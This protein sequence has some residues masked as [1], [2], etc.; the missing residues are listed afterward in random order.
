MG[1]KNQVYGQLQPLI[2]AFLSVPIEMPLIECVITGTIQQVSSTSEFQQ[3]VQQKV[4]KWKWAY[5]IQ[6]KEHL[7]FPLTR[8]RDLPKT[9]SLTKLYPGSS[10]PS[11]QLGLNL[12]LQRLEQTLNSI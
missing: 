5:I 10:E 3:M 2:F 11:S 1:L 9:L 6:Q 7:F 8:G 12:G 4:I